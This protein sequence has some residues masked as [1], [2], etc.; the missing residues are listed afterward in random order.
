MGSKTQLEI[1]GLIKDPNFHVAKSIAEVNIY[2]FT[3][4]KNKNIFFPFLHYYSGCRLVIAGTTTKLSQGISG[5]HTSA[6][7]WIWLAQISV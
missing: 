4:K 3:T 5:S 2:N 6:T 1:V 7:F